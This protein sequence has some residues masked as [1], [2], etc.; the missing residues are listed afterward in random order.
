MYVGE[1]SSQANTLWKALAQ[2]TVLP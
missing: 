1:Y 2:A